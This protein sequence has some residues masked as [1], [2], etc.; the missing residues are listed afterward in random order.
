MLME[1][2]M[3][4]QMMEHEENLKLHW[5]TPGQGRPA[6]PSK[7]QKQNSLVVHTIRSHFNLEVFM[8]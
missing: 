3:K 4:E 8:V 7:K 1:D 6:T 2:L 5:E